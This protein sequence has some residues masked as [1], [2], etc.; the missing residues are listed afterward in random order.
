MGHTGD[1]SRF[2]TADR[3]A[4]YNATAPIEASSGPTVRHRLN[5]RGNRQL[6]HALHIAAM[7][8]ISHNSVGR[9]YY[10]RKLA[11]GK[12]PKEAHPLAEA[13]ASATTS[14]ATSSPTPLATDNSGP[15]RTTRDDSSIQ[16]GR[17][18]P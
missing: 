14:T 8:Q 5:Q 6:N 3:Y 1:I 13:H 11:E 2:A 12:R 18:E 16:R 17:L 4:S 10:E 7:V 15:G 9:T